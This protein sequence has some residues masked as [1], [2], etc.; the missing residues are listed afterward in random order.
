RTDTP[1]ALA[2]I[3]SGSSG[4]GE[5]LLISGQDRTDNITDAVL[6]EELEKDMAK[7]FESERSEAK[8]YKLANGE[9]EVFLE[10]IQPS[11]SLIIFGAGFDA[12][13]VS[14]LAKSLGWEVQV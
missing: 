2:T 7:L 4:V 12:R 10:L 8:H 6:K 3:F 14:N 11:V 9:A 5:K 1:V 13:P